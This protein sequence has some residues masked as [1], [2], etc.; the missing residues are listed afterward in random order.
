MSLPSKQEVL[1]KA[2]G[3]SFSERVKYGA[4]LGHSQSKNAALPTLL[5]DSRSVRTHFHPVRRAARREP[6]P[7]HI[8]DFFPTPIRLLRPDFGSPNLFFCI[9]TPA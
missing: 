1:D 7:L 8:P 2:H 5:S 9:I 4:K 3:S 6:L